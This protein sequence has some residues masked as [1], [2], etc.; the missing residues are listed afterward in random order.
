M[1]RGD[2]TSTVSFANSCGLKTLENQKKEK[3][4]SDP[5]KR[6][7]RGDRILFCIFWA[8]LMLVRDRAAA[9]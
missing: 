3:R 7:L 9:A 8:F 6:I 2:V 4:K 1:V 5:R